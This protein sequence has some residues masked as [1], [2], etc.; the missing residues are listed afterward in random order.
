MRRFR[1]P[2]H[3]HVTNWSIVAVS[4]VAIAL[5][6]WNADNLNQLAVLCVL[7]IIFVLNGY[8]LVCFSICIDNQEIRIYS[9]FKRCKVVDLQRI[10]RC[11]RSRRGLPSMSNDDLALFDEMGNRILIRGQVEG[12][13][14]MVEWIEELVE[15]REVARR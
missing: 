12:G 7:C 3:M 15:R 2:M 13:S 8:W 9:W 1:V 6:P 10:S 4:L 14:A 5:T 11:E